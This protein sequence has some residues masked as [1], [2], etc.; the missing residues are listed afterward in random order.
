MAGPAYYPVP[1]AQSNQ[2][3]PQNPQEMQFGPHPHHPPSK[4]GIWSFNIVRTFSLVSNFH[5]SPIGLTQ[6]TL[7]FYPVDQGQSQISHQGLQQ[8][9]LMNGPPNIPGK[10]SILRIPSEHLQF[11]L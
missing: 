1:Q 8:P 10:D 6:T 11:L 5:F 3:D 2:Q 4:F 7:P 9:E